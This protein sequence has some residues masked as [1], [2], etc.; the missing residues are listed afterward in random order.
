[1]LDKDTKKNIKPLTEKELQ[2]MDSEI[3]KFRTKK[4]VGDKEIEPIDVDAWLV[5]KG[6][7][8][9][10]PA[11][12]RPAVIG[13][14]Y[15]EVETK[16]NFGVMVHKFD[17]YLLRLRQYTSWKSQFQEQEQLE[18]KEKEVLGVDNSVA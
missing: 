2:E 13:N 3:A 14:A 10:L 9:K 1:M 8:K 7:L 11:P 5:H 4:T 6:A 16:D 12:Y 15:I 18:E 17:L